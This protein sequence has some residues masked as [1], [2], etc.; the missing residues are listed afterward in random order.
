MNDQSQGDMIASF[1]FASASP[2]SWRRRLNT[3]RARFGVPQLKCPASTTEEKTFNV[4]IEFF[5]SFLR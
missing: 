4:G 3:N 5:F 2:I 1:R